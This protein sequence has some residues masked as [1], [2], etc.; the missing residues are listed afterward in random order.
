MNG[1]SDLKPHFGKVLFDHQAF[2]VMHHRKRLCFIVDKHRQSDQ[3][4][5][6]FVTLVSYSVPHELFHR[7][8]CHYRLS[9]ES[10]LF[11][12]VHSIMLE[13][14]SWY[15]RTLESLESFSEKFTVWWPRDS[16]QWPCD[17]L[18][19]L[20]CQWVRFLVVVAERGEERVVTAVVKLGFV[21]GPT[22]AGYRGG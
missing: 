19:T 6:V 2:D 12:E 16:L 10:I 17:S 13:H 1:H 20:P 11:H 18:R 14:I 4:L 8:K 9:K 3:L 22:A 15:S 21:G 7:P 5:D